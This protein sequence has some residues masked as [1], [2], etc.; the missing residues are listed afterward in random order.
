MATVTRKPMPNRWVRFPATW[1]TYLR[2][3]RERGESYRP[4][5]IFYRGRLTIVSPGTPHERL[6]NRLASLLKDLLDTLDIDYAPLGSV[7]LKQADAD[8]LGVEADSHLL[9]ARS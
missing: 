8:A 1:Q 4:K 5:L 2:L 3:D 7:T 6:R 9:L